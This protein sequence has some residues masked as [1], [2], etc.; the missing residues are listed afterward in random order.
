MTGEHS[1]ARRAAGKRAWARKSAAEKAAILARLRRVR[2]SH[3][4]ERRTR[5]AASS[6]SSTHSGG[7]SGGS[8]TAEKAKPK[9]HLA[10]YA[11]VAGSVLAAAGAGG[12]EGVP[13]DMSQ[14]PNRTL[15]VAME[16]A[17]AI[18]KDAGVAARVAAPAA[19]G[20]VVS[21]LADKLGLNKWLARRRSKIRV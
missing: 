19:G 1:A 4:G 12:V 14:K 2:P 15:N 9:P 11:G 8:S 16:N 21:Y 7:H 17:S 13:Y 18:V 6:G 3:A 10:V 5:R 20:V